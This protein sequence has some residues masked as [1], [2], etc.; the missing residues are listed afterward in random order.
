M[1]IRNTLAV[2]AAS[3]LLGA[4]PGTWRHPAGSASRGTPEDVS[5]T[6]SGAILLAPGGK[7]LVP[8]ETDEPT[9][10]LLWAA[11][12]DG[13]QNLF[14]GGGIGARVIRVDKNGVPEPFFDIGDFGVRA[15]ASDLSGQIYVA[16]MPTGRIYKLDDEGGAE[17]FF[18]PEERYIWALATD[19][20]DRLYV[21]TG[22]RGVIYVVSGPGEAEV[23]LDTDEAHITSMATD[24][25]G[26]IIAGSAGR[27]LLYRLSNEGHADLLLD[28][29]L[30]EIS[31]IVVASDGTV[32]AAAIDG[33][34]ARKRER[35]RRDDL[36]IEVTTAAEEDPLEDPAYP[37]DKI[38]VDL[39]ELFS[40]DVG[41]LRRPRTIVY[42]VSPGKT[43]VEIW[44]ST[45]E[46]VYSLALDSRGHLLMGSGPRGMLYRA[47]PDGTVTGVRRYPAAHITGLVQVERGE[48]IV[49]TSN[50]GRVYTLE[51]TPATSGFY[52]SPVHDA[53]SIASWGAIRWDADQPQGTRIDIEARSGNSPVPGS[54]WS[55]WS[56]IGSD[57]RGSAL[58]VPAARYVQWRARLSR[59]KTEATPILRGVTVTYL[60]ENL[61]PLVR[62]V[63][64]GEPGTPRPGPTPD[65]ATEKGKAGA[66]SAPGDR[67]LTWNSTD[68]SDDE[69][70]HAI[71]A[72]R[73]NDPEWVTIAEGV[74]ESPF[75]LNPEPL[76]EGRY[77]VRVIADDALENG[78]I[79]A[80]SGEGHTA[81]F[82]VD[83]T[84]PV[85]DPERPLVEANMLNLQF[86]VRDASS[87]VDHCSWS[88]NK[89]GPWK[90]LFAVDGIADTPVESFS[91]R[92]PRGDVKSILFLKA[93]DAS[94]NSSTLEV[95]LP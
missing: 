49:L 86:K 51:P 31:A 4:S 71:S 19:P 66:I 70:R 87:P 92:I 16:T 78:E 24:P 37:P 26:R 28:S 93:E 35:R 23:F 20:F 75:A 22:E 53:G 8:G 88:S 74:K 57:S 29:P 14:V 77:V 1:L 41:A 13:R 18:E 40:G 80:L 12:M 36:T 52:I 7:E 47:E 50:P 55:S 95:V 81:P 39:G 69:L 27:G 64:L 2:L 84:P 5:I 65:K 10:S 67:W 46:R 44:S 9:P 17:V 42:R 38:V 3:L 61:P 45:T 82:F 73:E 89:D 94:S 72:R 11:A 43:P 54:T 56:K 58:S 32:Y 79:R 34:R 6:S 90:S 48:T 85:I 91:L 60:P 25:T 30:A 63:R 76:A 15:I 68:P 62:N 83:K 59:L 33:P 21:A